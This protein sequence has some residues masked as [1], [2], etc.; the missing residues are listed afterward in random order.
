[1]LKSDIKLQLTH[2][3]TCYHVA[4]DG[5]M[6]KPAGADRYNYKAKCVP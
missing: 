6:P 3:L 5:D 4:T 2:S 1:V